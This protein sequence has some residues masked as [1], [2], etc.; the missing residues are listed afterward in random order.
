VAETAFSSG[1]S[2]LIGFTRLDPSAFGP[3]LFG[4]AENVLDRILKL[5]F[6]EAAV[7]DSFL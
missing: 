4:F 3:H 6:D 1:N 7:K 5:C 2:M